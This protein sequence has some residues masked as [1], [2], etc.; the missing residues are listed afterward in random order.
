ALALGRYGLLHISKAEALVFGL[1]WRRRRPRS[2]LPNRD[3]I[4][5]SDLIFHVRL[6]AGFDDA[7]AGRGHRLLAD[8]VDPLLRLT[9]RGEQSVPLS[10]ILVAL[11]ETFQKVAKRNGLVA[12]FLCQVDANLVGIEL[13]ATIEVV[14]EN[15]LVG[16]V[17]VTAQNARARCS[18]GSHFHRV[19]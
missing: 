13:V 19:A 3:G 10:L 1:G 17:G 7:L 14:F 15:H 16:F 5:W 11:V 4:E 9:M 18:F 2:V 8:L 6:E 12:G